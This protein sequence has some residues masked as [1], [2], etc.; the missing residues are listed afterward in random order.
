VPFTAAVD[1]DRC[2]SSGLCV[3]DAPAAFR[4]DDDE[5]AEPTHATPPLGDDELLAVA[6]ACPAGAISLTDEHGAEVDRG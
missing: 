4:F 2:I 6:R 3:A 1:K 5:L